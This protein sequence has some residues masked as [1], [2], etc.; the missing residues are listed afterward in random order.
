[1]S[2]YAGS[3]SMAYWTRSLAAGS[4]SFSQVDSTGVREVTTWVLPLVV[5]GEREVAPGTSG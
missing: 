4:A 3:G 5:T 2:S 1:M